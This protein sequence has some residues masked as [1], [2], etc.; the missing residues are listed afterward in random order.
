MN[1][2]LAIGMTIESVRSW[3]DEILQHV[4]NSM[5]FQNPTLSRYCFEIKKSPYVGVLKVV[6]E[7]MYERRM[8]HFDTL[9]HSLLRL[10]KHIACIQTI[11][12]AFEACTDLSSL[13]IKCLKLERGKQN[14]LKG[15]GELKSFVSNTLSASEVENYCSA[16]RLSS[17]ASGHNANV[18]E[19][20][21]SILETTKTTKVH[22]ELALLNKLLKDRANFFAGDRYIGC[23]K[24]VC[25]CCTRYVV[26]L[27]EEERVELCGGHGNL[28]LGWR[29]PASLHNSDKAAL[30]RHEWIL[31]RLLQDFHLA[32]QDKIQDHV[33]RYNHADSSTRIST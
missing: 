12:R 11:I 31:R 3:L 14:P 28:Y 13:K 9:H 33:L 24:A 2:D 8:T 20:M 27:E 1:S 10:R 30:R 29:P 4:D 25:Y 19:Y 7:R 32:I 5:S 16:A 6:A 17:F 18:E 26:A 22:A 15:T 23:S 21:R